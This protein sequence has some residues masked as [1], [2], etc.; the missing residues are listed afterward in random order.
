[1]F[2]SLLPSETAHSLSG[3]RVCF[4]LNK[5]DSY[6]SLRLR[7]LPRRR[8]NLNFTLN[9]WRSE[10]EEYDKPQP[11]ASLGLEGR[12]SPLLSHPLSFAFLLSVA[13]LDLASGLSWA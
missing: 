3:C 5:S 10:S 2:R 11:L 12:Y 8:E 1:M 7:I 9:Y 4:S 13:F 6:L